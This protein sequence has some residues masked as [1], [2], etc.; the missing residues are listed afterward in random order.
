[1]KLKITAIR[2]TGDLNKERIVMKVESSTDIGHY[3]LL[4]VDTVDGQPTTG[5]RNTY[6]FPNKNINTGDYVV[7]YSKE[8]FNSEHE[9][10]TVRSHFFYLGSKKTIWDEDNVGATVLHAPDWESFLPTN[11]KAVN[12]S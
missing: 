2:D 8:G 5:V 11:S 6:W 1:M 9:F 7:V 12:P 3:V 10:K 4:C